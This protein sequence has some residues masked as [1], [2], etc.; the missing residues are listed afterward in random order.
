MKKYLTILW[1]AVA[2]LSVSC[3]KTLDIDDTSAHELVLNGVPSAGKEAFVYFAQT[4]F[5]LDSSVN[6]PVV[7]ASVTLTVNGTAMQP[8]REERCKYFFGYNLQEQ[9]ELEI[10]V[11]TPDGRTL[12][13]ATYVPLFPDV[14]QFKATKFDSPSFKLFKVDMSLNDHADQ[15]EYYNIVVTERDSGVRFNEWTAEYDTVD[16]IHA[17]YFL[18]PYNPNV[19]SNEVCPYLPLGGYLYSRIMFMDKNIAGQQEDLQLYILQTID[20]NEVEP[21]KH[22]YFVQ[23]ES[24]TPARWNYI[25][26]S[27]QQ[28]SAFSFFAE[29]GDVWDNVQGGLGIFAGTASRKYAFMPDTLDVSQSQSPMILQRYE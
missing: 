19:T 29:Q 6:Q 18:V 10:D 27:S 12:H 26:S 2:A 5:F 22:E 28:A 4:R 1:L 3:E 20:T 25:I 23:V 14:S 15:D 8:V 9:D 21:F 11:A 24:V 13:A 17:T 16:T 7:G